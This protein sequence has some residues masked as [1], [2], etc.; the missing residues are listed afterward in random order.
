MPEVQG[1]RIIS[2]AGQRYPTHIE[3]I[4]EDG[5]IEKL[6]EVGTIDFGEHP[7]PASLPF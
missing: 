2:G 1:R 6:L 5:S 3:K 7:D 4:K